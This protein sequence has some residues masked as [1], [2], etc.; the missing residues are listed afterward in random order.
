MTE[1]RW[2]EEMA[3]KYLTTWTR[4]GGEMGRK[5]GYV[6]TNA[7]YRNTTR[8]AHS[9]IYWHANMNQNQQHRVQTMQLYYNESK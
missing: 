8:Q 1:E 3:D 9:N 4:T 7:K 5:I 2:G 6:A